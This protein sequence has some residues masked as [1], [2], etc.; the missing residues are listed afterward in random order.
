MSFWVT[1][2]SYN[3]QAAR[4]LTMALIEDVD[5]GRN[6]IVCSIQCID[7]AVMLSFIELAAGRSQLDRFGGTKRDD[8][9][10]VMRIDHSGN[11]SSSASCAFAPQHQGTPAVAGSN[12]IVELVTVSVSATG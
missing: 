7:E 10:I 5:L 3:A 1:K 6:A 9:G 11:D 2:I 8:L 12:T 4:S